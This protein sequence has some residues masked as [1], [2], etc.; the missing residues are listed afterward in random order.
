MNFGASLSSN[1]T[2]S[3]HFY[4]LFGTHNAVF[5][6]VKSKVGGKNDEDKPDE[7]MVWYALSL[8][9]CT[10]SIHTA[11]ER[12]RSQFQQDI[13]HFPV[14]KYLQGTSTEEE[15]SG[16]ASS[17]LVSPQLQQ[18]VA[19]K[20]PRDSNYDVIESEAAPAKRHVVPTKK[21]VTTAKNFFAAKSTTTS[22]PTSSSTFASKKTTVGT[23]S[24]SN[25]NKSKST[26]SNTLS[27]PPK[28]STTTNNINNK[29]VVNKNGKGDEEKENVKNKS[30]KVVGNAD[31]FVGDMDEEEDS[32]DDAESMEEEEKEVPKPPL[33]VGKPKA[34][35]RKATRTATTRSDS[36]DEQKETVEKDSTE[37][38]ETNA[39]K[40]T[41]TDNGDVTR[42]RARRKKMVEKTCTDE[43]GYLHT[44][45]EVIWED[46]PS[47]EEDAYITVSSRTNKNTKTTKKTNPPPKKVLKQGSI[48]GFFA[49][50]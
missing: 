30:S 4:A 48:L 7:S 20:G 47:D 26:Q 18:R 22:K 34:A 19:S 35:A 3:T 50:K 31:D 29:K 15:T 6:L 11:H 37:A 5:Q 43:H 42:K 45:T 21:S 9:D 36:D 16:F 2:R 10:E 40:S 32:E 12:D 28:K 27:F 24:S 17:L 46:V 14:P 38:E 33:P 8:D 44:T 1:H 23:V 41:S 25:T 39:K 49:K 13:P